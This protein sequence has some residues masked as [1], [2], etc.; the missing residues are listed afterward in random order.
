MP[1][2]WNVTVTQGEK[3]KC[4]TS[5]P[6]FG[7]RLA[8]SY[9][10]QQNVGTHLSQKLHNMHKNVP[11]TK[12]SEIATCNKFRGKT[13]AQ[14]QQL[15]RF[16]QTPIWR[17]SV[18]LETWSHIGPDLSDS[19]PAQWRHPLAPCRNVA[20]LGTVLACPA[21]MKTTVQ[22]RTQT[23][24][25]AGVQRRWRSEF[26][27]VTVMFLTKE[28]KKTFAQAFRHSLLWGTF[29]SRAD[30]RSE[31]WRSALDCLSANNSISMTCLS[32]L[33]SA[34][35]SLSTTK[36]YVSKA[37]FELPAFSMEASIFPQ[38]SKVSTVPKP[39]RACNVRKLPANWNLR[40]PFEIA[41]WNRRLQKISW[42]AV[43]CH[44]PVKT[45]ASL[46]TVAQ[47]GP[48]SNY[49]ITGA[50]STCISSQFS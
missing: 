33:N 14:R 37:S 25:F 46:Q 28:Q 40:S 45:R 38:P 20:P 48:V 32:T 6:F 8:L 35:T 12:L 24:I 41:R 9:W 42:H 44:L 7:H 31:L 29:F 18:E 27:L 17:P 50:V 30:G 3:G 4:L 19:K 10:F 49:D 43:T 16:L 22:S 23:R 13:R 47:R 36:K 21:D 11:S 15:V 2:T 1:R 39:G 26:S 34:T 5:E